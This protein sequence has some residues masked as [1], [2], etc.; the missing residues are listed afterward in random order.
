LSFLLYSHFVVLTEVNTHAA[1]SVGIH[2]GRLEAGPTG[3]DPMTD[4]IN[5]DEL[6]SR[7]PELGSHL[8]LSEHHWSTGLGNGVVVDRHVVLL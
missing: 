7:P 2:V 5:L 4:G 1:G 6:D 3:M 8:N